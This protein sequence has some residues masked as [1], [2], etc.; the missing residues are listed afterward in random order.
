MYAFY[1]KNSHIQNKSVFVIFNAYDFYVMKTVEIVFS[2]NNMDYG[3][4]LFISVIVPT[5]TLDTVHVSWSEDARN[6][7]AKM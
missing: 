2:L 4:K 3:H 1:C 5:I 6:H 7:Q